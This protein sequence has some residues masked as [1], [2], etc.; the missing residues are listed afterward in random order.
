MKNYDEFQFKKFAVA[1]SECGMKVGTDAVLL[2]AWADLATCRRILDV[3][4]GSGIL[5]LMAAQRNDKAQ[6]DAVELDCSAAGEAER[7]VNNSPWKPRINVINCDFRDFRG[8]M[9]YDYVISNPPFFETGERALEQKR[10]MARHSDTLPFEDFFR[11]CRKLLADDGTI[12]IIAP[13]EAKQRIEFLAGETNL[14]LRR[15]TAVRTTSKRPI[16]RYLWEFT[17][18]QV[19]LVEDELTLHEGE[20]RSKRFNDLTKEFYLR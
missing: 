9:K 13:A 17:N 18:C 19:E 14:W 10:A 15:R 8:S 16:K 7:N 6:I 1:H 12:G 5:A 4:T 11:C 3:G 2:G 20:N